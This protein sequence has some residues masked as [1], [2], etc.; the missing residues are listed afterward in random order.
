MPT[1]LHRVVAL[2]AAALFLAGSQPAETAPPFPI[3]LSG[4]DCND[5]SGQCYLTDWTLESDGRFGETWG[6]VGDWYYNQPNSVLTM[7]YDG[8]QGWGYVYSGVR[9]AG[10]SCYYGIVLDKF[11]Q[12]A[13]EFQACH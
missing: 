6:F 4:I 12:E 2:A 9:I 13:G 8:G 10:T 11:G 5:Y 7:K 3:V 1:T